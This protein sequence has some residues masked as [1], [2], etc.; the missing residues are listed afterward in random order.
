MFYMSYIPCKICANIEKFCCRTKY[1]AGVIFRME[2]S[3]LLVWNNPLFFTDFLCEIGRTAQMREDASWRA[4]DCMHC[5][6][7]GRPRW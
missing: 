2:P 1:Y 4:I 7:Q 5:T 3:T 6:V